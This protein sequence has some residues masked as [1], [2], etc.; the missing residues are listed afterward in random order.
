MSGKRIERMLL[1]LDREGAR[2]IFDKAVMLARL[3]GARLEIFLCDAE[4]AYVQQRQYDAARAEIAR[5]AC[6]TD[7]R[8]FLEALVR[9]APHEGVPVAIDTVCESPL[10]LGI[11]RKVQ[12]SAPDLVI[13][14]VSGG[15]RRR[16]GASDWDLARSCPAPLLLTKGAAWS[17]SPLVAA[18]IDLSA[19]ESPALT[20][21]IL[22]AAKRFADAGHGTLEVLHAGRFC[23]APDVA[24]AHRAKLEKCA[25]EAGVAP[26]ALHLVDGEPADVLTEF[27]TARHYDLI[28]LGAL[29]HRR[30]LTAVVG[31][32]TGRLLETIESDFLLV[33]PA[34]DPAGHAIR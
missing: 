31:T 6:L 10:Y 8:R 13:R 16:F 12:R 11:V 15:S 2:E 3:F 17:A 26:S 27:A 21:E 4:R 22:D 5:D 9:S 23:H 28:V 19:E 32:L 18:A 14:G 7:A 34:S 30:A 24:A 1:A 25:E 29:T 33:K 20:C